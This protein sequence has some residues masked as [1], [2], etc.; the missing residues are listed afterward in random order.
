MVSCR[1]L[2]VTNAKFM[3][4]QFTETETTGY[5]QRILNSFVGVLFGILLFL[6]A[7]VLLYWNEGRINLA[8]LVK[9]STEI[10]A[11]GAPSAEIGEFV[12]VTGTLTSSETLGDGLYLQP[13]DYVALRRTSEMYAWEEST[14]SQSQT[15]AGGS[16]TT[17]T[18]YTYTKDWS[19]SPESSTSFKQPNGH[20]NPTKSVESDTFKVS[21]AKVGQYSLELQRLNLPTPSTVTL[22]NTMLLPN[23]GATLAGSYLFLGKGSLTSPEVGDLRIQYRSL[24][25]GIQA[26]VVGAL[27]QGNTLTPYAGPRNISVY[28]LFSGNRTEAID[29]LSFENSALTWGFRTA[30]FFM[31]WIGMSMVVAPLNILLDVLP[32]LG[33]LSRQATGFVTFGLSL[34]LSGLTI[35]TS[36][37][38]HNPI[39]LFLAIGL[40]G[41][42]LF[43]FMRK[44]FAPAD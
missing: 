27:A 3:S 35:I 30:G 14:D 44:K 39:M 7:F 31:M 38:L 17:S 20:T 1:S 37:I 6:A 36:I 43:K 18:T 16:E 24:N 32:F 13:G 42:F 25:Q 41:F 8:Q 2:D 10:T 19:E 26:T 29:A 4:D 9:T 23:S 12:S 21:Q 28:R 22:N 11:T 15:N 33:N 34:V 40:S 5:F